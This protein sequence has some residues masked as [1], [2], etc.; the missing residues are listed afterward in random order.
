MGINIK[1][2]KPGVFLFH[3]YHKNDM[4]CVI[5]GGPWSFDNALLVFNVIKQGEDPVKVPLVEVDF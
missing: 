3:F 1:D 4:D 2:M 5:K